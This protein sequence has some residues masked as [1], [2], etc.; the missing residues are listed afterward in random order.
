MKK[1]HE[2]GT[3][4]V[5]SLGGVLPNEGGQRGKVHEWG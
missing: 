2:W 5:K 3:W 1:G 4:R